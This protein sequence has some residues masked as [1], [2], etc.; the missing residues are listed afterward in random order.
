[1]VPEP[2]KDAAPQRRTFIGVL[3]RRFAMVDGCWLEWWL[4]VAAPFCCGTVMQ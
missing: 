4:V 1:M 2:P 3:L